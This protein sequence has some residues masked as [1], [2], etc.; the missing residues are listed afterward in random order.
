M[1][2][3]EA[4]KDASDILNEGWKMALMN[5]FHAAN[6]MDAIVARS[7]GPPVSTE[8]SDEGEGWKND[9]EPPATLG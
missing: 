4:F 9:S 3:D 2:R 7:T 8:A 6:V 5:L 1:I